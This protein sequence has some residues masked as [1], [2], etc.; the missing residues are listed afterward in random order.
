MLLDLLSKKRIFTKVKAEDWYDVGR[1]VGEI[2]LKDNL[3]EDRYI[4]AMIKSIEDN[5]PYIVV[6]EGIAVFH[7][8]PEDGVKETGMSL[9]TLDSPVEF[10]HDNNDPVKIAFA[11]GSINNDQHVEAMSQLMTVLMEDGSVDK[12][13]A[14]D[15][16]SEV[17][18]YINQI[19]NKNRQEKEGE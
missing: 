11:F 1:K 14:K 2:L 17:F 10:G 8:R 15:T 7:A 6:G 12:I 4:D 5:G 18:D 13:Y 9:I 16:S 3:V 19:V